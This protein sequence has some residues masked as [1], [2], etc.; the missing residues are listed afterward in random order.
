M[1]RY[2]RTIWVALALVNMLVLATGSASA[3][4][5]MTEYTGIEYLVQV[6]NQGEWTFP[7]GNVHVRGAVHEYYDETDDPRITGHFTIVA[8]VNWDANGAGNSWGT[9]RR[10]VDCE[11]GGVGIWEG[12]WTGKHYAGGGNTIHGVGHGISGCVEGLKQKQT[13][14]SPGAGQVGT[15]TGRV[16]DPHGE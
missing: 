7:N 2:G 16:L 3:L 10:V 9:Y 13:V 12:T 11:D 6:H 4:A 5:T 14:E 15:V 8:N 1:K